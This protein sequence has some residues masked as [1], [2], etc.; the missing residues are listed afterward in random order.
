MLSLVR[1]KNKYFHLKCKNCLAYDN[2]VVLNS[3][4]VGLDPGKTCIDSRVHTNPCCTCSQIK[5]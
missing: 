3:E 5:I 2:A 4:V 1:F